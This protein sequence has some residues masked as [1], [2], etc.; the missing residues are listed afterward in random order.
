MQAHLVDATLRELALGQA[1]DLTLVT[2][3]VFAPRCDQ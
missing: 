2:G 3:R 1:H